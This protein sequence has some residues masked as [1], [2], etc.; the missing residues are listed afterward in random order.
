MFT[1]R[2]L[3][4]H[5]TSLGFKEILANSSSYNRNG[6]VVAKQDVGDRQEVYVAAV[7]GHQDDG[8]LLYGLLELQ[9]DTKTNLLNNKV[10]F[11]LLLY[12]R[13]SPY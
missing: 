8:V 5:A 11:K 9:D 12:E 6:N 2:H 7:V 4:Y 13:R 3:R 10:C 1:P